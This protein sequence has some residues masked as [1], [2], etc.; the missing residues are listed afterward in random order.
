M[1]QNKVISGEELDVRSRASA[2]KGLIIKEAIAAHL[3]LCLFL[4]DEG[5]EP[6]LLE[7]TSLPNEPLELGFPLQEQ[8]FKTRYYAWMDA[9]VQKHHFDRWWELKPIEEIMFMLLDLPLSPDANGEIYYFILAL[10]SY[11]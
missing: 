4:G 5:Y 7:Q 1:D 6:M 11:Q 10:K 9:Y 8:E 2:M 3:K